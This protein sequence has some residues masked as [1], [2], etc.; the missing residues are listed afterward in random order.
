VPI[1]AMTAH[2]TA[3]DRQKCLAAGMDGYLSKPIDADETIAVVE[4]WAVGDA[5]G[6]GDSPHLPERP[7]Q[8]AVGARYFAQ[9]GTV[10]F[11]GPPADTTVFDLAVAMEKCMNKRDLLGQ[12][13]SFFFKDSDVLLPRM[14][15]AL[16][17]GDIKEV[18]R[19]GHRLKG[20]LLHLGAD[21]AREA[22]RRV[23]QLMLH[24]G[25]QADA[26]EAVAALERACDRLKQALAPHRP[27]PRV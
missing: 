6:K 4:S 25:Q 3:A 17:A 15:A 23:E 12:I 9:M 11:S 7:D 5:G 2:A 8:P 27:P 13:I 10:P 26:A 14:R 19:L 22:A 21:A 20:T 24:G 1:I 16:Q 18:G